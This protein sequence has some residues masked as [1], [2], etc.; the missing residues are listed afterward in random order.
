MKYDKLDVSFRKRA[1]NIFRQILHD[2]SSSEKP[3]V[4]DIGCGPGIIGMLKDSKDN[5]FGVE[6]DKELIK[7]ASTYCE[8]VYDID[9]NSFKK[10]A[11]VESNFDFIFFGDV[12]E[13]VLEPEKLLKEITPLL[14]DGGFIVISLPNIAQLP[15]RLQLLFGNFNYTET[16]VLDK[17][18]LHLYTMKT[19]KEL[20]LGAGLRIERFYSS[21]TIVSFIDI[22]PS[23]LS[24]Q[25]IFLCSKK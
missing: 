3:M 14:R 24:S 11:I 2:Y 13:H 19:A 6:R 21:G 12:L 22:F 20:I 1:H 17:S 5:I 8:K 18:H 16:G 10:Q 4:L 15:F 23:L 7:I 9:L 25:L